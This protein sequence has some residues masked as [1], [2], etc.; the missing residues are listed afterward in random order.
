M[1][2]CAKRFSVDSGRGA[3]GAAFTTV[4]ERC[5]RQQSVPEWA[6]DWSFGW[7]EEVGDGGALMEF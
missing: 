5:P 7:R 3:R 4:D 2:L 1:M 6:S